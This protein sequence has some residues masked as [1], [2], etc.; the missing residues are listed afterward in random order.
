M[1]NKKALV[2]DQGFFVREFFLLFR[3]P[4]FP[5]TKNLFSPSTHPG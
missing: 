2:L 5:G 1:Y 4:I 3:F